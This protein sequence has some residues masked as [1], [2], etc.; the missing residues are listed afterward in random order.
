MKIPNPERQTREHG[1]S[2]TEGINWG[3][4]RKMALDFRTHCRIALRDY[5]TE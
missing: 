5:D 1:N 3:G 2:S 4:P